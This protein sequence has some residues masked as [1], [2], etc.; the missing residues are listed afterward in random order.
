MVSRPTKLYPLANITTI[1]KNKGSRMD[2]KNDSGIFILTVLKKMLDK[3]IYFDNYEQIDANTSD[4]NIGS[5]RN[6]NIKDHLLVHH[7]VINSVIYGNEECIDLPIYEQAF[8]SLWLEDCLNDIFDTLPEENRNDK[9]ALLHNSNQ[10]N[11]IAVKTAAGLTEHVNIPNKVQ[12]GGTWGSLLFS[13]TI[14]TLG[15]KC[16]KRGEYYYLYKKTSRIFP[17]N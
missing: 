6:R 17:L 13:N 5:R 9:I 4:S 15:K 16:R 14:D 12:Q 8:D 7:G 2:M 3:F 1:F 11:L 10:V